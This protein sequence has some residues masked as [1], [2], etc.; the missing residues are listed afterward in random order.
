[1]RL[2][3]WFIE[4]IFVY[5]RW[6]LFKIRNLRISFFFKKFIFFIL[7]NRMQ[8]ILRILIIVIT[9]SLVFLFNFVNFKICVSIVKI[10]IVL[11]YCVLILNSIFKLIFIYWFL[12]VNI[13]WIIILLNFNSLFNF[14]KSHFI[15]TL[16][17]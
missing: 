2:I 16:R 13:L 6:K 15:V 14:F 1:M 5:H 10:Y 3:F 8:I 17:A 7:Y 9:F 11:N 12:W 4:H